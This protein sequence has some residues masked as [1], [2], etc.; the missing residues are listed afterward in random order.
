MFRCS[1]IWRPFKKRYQFINKIIKEF[2]LASS[3]RFQFVQMGDKVSAEETQMIMIMMDTIYFCDFFQF[4]DISSK[5]RGR[6]EEDDDTNQTC[7]QHM[8]RHATSYSFV[9]IMSLRNIT[10]LTNTLLQALSR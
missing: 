10:R 4:C 1:A 6:F 7:P 2:Q 5:F 8:L 9:C 3:K